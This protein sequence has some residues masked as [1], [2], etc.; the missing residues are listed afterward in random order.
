MR[1]G[2]EI[3][4]SK[5]HRGESV[6]STLAGPRSQLA[7]VFSVWFNLVFCNHGD[8]SYGAGRSILSSPAG[9]DLCR[10]F[11]CCS[12]LLLCSRI[13]FHSKNHRQPED[14]QY[15]LPQ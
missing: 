9:I 15:C 12:V 6:H 13:E 8:N 7:V 14:Q 11:R 10:Q 2:Y 4:V 1:E 5:G 3:S